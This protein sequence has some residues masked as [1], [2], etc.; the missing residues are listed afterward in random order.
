LF[1]S[2]TIYNILKQCYN[3][4]TILVPEESSEIIPVHVPY[5]EFEDIRINLRGPELGNTEYIDLGII[6]R[7]T[8]GLTQKTYYDSDWPIIHRLSI[9][10]TALSQSVANEL[11]DFVTLT[12]GKKIRYNDHLDNDWDGFIL[13]PT[14][15]I[16]Q[17]GR[18][19]QY[20]FNFDFQ[21]EQV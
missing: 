4:L 10:V 11:L 7:K 12:I 20:N 3:I 5:L 1:S 2:R 14:N 17:S 6:N 13:T 21:G 19:D 16:V 9:T 8:R 15:K 18:G